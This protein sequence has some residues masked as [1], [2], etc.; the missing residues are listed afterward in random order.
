MYSHIEVNADPKKEI[1][2]E[3]QMITDF[4]A[5]IHIDLLRFLGDGQG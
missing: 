1:S 2:I 5:P 4:F 3:L